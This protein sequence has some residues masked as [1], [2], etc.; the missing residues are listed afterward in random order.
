MFL[1]TDIEQYDYCVGR[2][3]EPLLD[4]KNFQIEI[5]LRVEIQKKLF[6]HCEIGRGDIPAANQRFFKWVWNHKP[7]YCEECLRPLNKFAAIYCSHILSRG[8]HPEMA[9]DAR[10]INILCPEHHCPW[11]HATTRKAMRIYS[12]NMRMIETLT[13]EYS[14][15]KLKQ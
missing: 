7:H 15:L 4:T 1:I 6:G 9:H 11:E 2:G 3:I 13:K 8:A 14:Q 10:N 5:S 12:K